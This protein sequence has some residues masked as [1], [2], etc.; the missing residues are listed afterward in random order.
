MQTLDQINA[1][2]GNDLRYVSLA[3][4]LESSRVGLKEPLKLPAEV[5]LARTY[6]VA[7]DTLRRAMSVLEKRGSV[8]RRRGHG[9][10]L[11]PIR[12]TPAATKHRA[13]GFVPPWWADSL[14]AWYTATVFDGISGFSGENNCHMNVLK[15]GRFED[16]V[17]ELLERISEKQLWGLVWVHPVPGQLPLLKAV[18]KRLP[19]VVVGRDYLAE[20]IYSVLPDYKQAAQ[21]LDDYAVSRGHTTY[22]VL[23]RSPSDPYCTSWLSGIE[24][25]HMARNAHFEDTNNYV[26]IT[27]FDRDRMA[28][29][30]MNFHLDAFRDVKLLLLTSSSYLAYLLADAAFR[31]RLS[32]DLS[33]MAFDYGSQAMHTYW[34]GTSFTHVTCDWSR[35]GSKAVEALFSILDG[36][37]SPQAVFEPVQ[38]VEGQTVRPYV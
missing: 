16:S 1:D 18:S 30:L 3:K 8:T 10:Y 33:L 13:I 31:E 25:A 4:A 9:T 15:V 36:D 19:C 11:Q 27:P 26:N 14:N 23:G 32:E 17:D 20:N 34:P 35:I 28:E 2:K 24:E 12:V 38:L 37:E 5:E 7:R 21:L 22:S 6:K 29:M